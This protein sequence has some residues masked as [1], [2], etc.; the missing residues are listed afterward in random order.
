MTAEELFK[1]A[2][3]EA[4]RREIEEIEAMDIDCTPTDKEKKCMNRLFRERVGG[5]YL[6]HPEVDNAYERIRSRIVRAF[7]LLANKCFH[8]RQS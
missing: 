7:L 3:E 1:K 6:P 8:K 4:C 2:V 5:D